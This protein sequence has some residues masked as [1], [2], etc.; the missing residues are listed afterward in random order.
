M[1]YG[2]GASLS[3]GSFQIRAEYETFEYETFDISEINDLYILSAEFAY[4]F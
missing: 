2:I 3:L 4:T 1:A